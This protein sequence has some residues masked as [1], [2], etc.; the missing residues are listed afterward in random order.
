MPSRN[1]PDLPSFIEKLHQI[2]LKLFNAQSSVIM[3]G[4]GNSGLREFPEEKTR[5]L[6]VK[7]LR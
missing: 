2:L 4:A 5:Y 7:H 1:C 6:T 3:P